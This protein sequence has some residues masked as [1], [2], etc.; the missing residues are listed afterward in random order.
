MKAELGALAPGQLARTWDRWSPPGFELGAEDLARCVTLCPATRLDF[1]SAIGAS[2]CGAVAWAAFKRS[3]AD[4]WQEGGDPQR[5]HLSCFAGEPA[6]VEALVREGLVRCAQGGASRVAFGADPDHLFPGVPDVGPWRRLAERLGF[7]SK[8]EA[9]D[10]ARDLAGYRP[11]SDPARALGKAGLR[12]ERSRAGQAK[13]L[14][15]FLAAEFPGRWRTDTARKVREEPEEIYLLTDGRQ[16]HGFAVTQTPR[17]ARPHAGAS[18]RRALGPDWAAL[19]PVGVAKGLRGEG[20]GDALL[21]SALL[22]LARDGAR[23]CVIDW[24]VLL[25]FYGRHGFRPWRRYT[26][27]EAA[28]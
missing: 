17:S 2:D 25:D 5:C 15:R 14:D 18:F 6:A 26:M 10:V 16:V 21:A 4:W 1:P 19:G 8:G 12:V 20:L 28:V 3:P 13:E 9:Y 7:E 11:P 27:A 23:L 24:T 22:G